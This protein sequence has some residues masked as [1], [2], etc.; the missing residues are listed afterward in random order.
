LQYFFSPSIAIAVAV[1]FAS[2]ANNPGAG[3]G[4]VLEVGEQVVKI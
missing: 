2:I 1:L 4:I 3:D